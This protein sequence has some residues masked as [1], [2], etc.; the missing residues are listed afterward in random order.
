MSSDL[1]KI[2]RSIRAESEKNHEPQPWWKQSKELTGI[3][4][5]SVVV[6]VG[7]YT[8]GW[9]YGIAKKYNPYLFIFEP[10][11][12]C[13]DI[14]E[15]VL[16]RYKCRVFRFGLGTT[17]GT[18]PVYNFRTDGCSFEE[19]IAGEKR[20]SNNKLQMVEIGNAFRQ[21]PITR[22][23]VMMVNIEGGEFELIPYMFTQGIFPKQLMFQCHDIYMIND[24]VRVVR[25]YYSN[26]WDFGTPL[27]LWRLNE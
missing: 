16:N 17:S 25:E 2:A 5:K 10:Q 3:T 12:W 15:E 21:I 18:Y 11:E 8:G 24:L 4:N 6:D 13:C 14:I 19:V 27:S 22:I 7:G 23:D 26:V 20:L 1:K 9:A